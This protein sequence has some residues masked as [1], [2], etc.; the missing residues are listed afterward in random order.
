MQWLPALTEKL[1]TSNLYFQS[2]VWIRQKMIC[3]V[4]PS[5]TGLANGQVQTLYSTCQE[6]M[7]LLIYHI[8]DVIE[9]LAPVLWQCWCW[10]L[11]VW[12]GWVIPGGA[13]RWRPLPRCRAGGETWFPSFCALFILTPLTIDWQ[14]QFFVP[15][16][17]LKAATSRVQ[18]CAPGLLQ[19]WHR[20]GC[21]QAGFNLIHPS[22]V[23][24][25]SRLGNKSCSDQIKLKPVLWSFSV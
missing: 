9:N 22:T 13:H 16:K 11:G 12:S 6:S 24:F 8:A 23:E 1:S 17:I 4:D 21:Q 18:C 7:E 3:Q 15:S 5:S 19:S 10:L 25:P 2:R 14:N 20:A